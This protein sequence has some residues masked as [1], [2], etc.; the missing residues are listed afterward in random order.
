M[1]LRKDMVP[2]R[3]ESGITTRSLEKSMYYPR[4]GEKGSSDPEG[5]PKTPRIDVRVGGGFP[6]HIRSLSIEGV[7]DPDVRVVP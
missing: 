7:V 4:S 1:Y 2:V 5:V 3:H 6:P